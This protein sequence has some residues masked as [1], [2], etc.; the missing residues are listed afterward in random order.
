[1][2]EVELNSDRRRDPS[3]QHYLQTIGKTRLLTRQQEFE[4]AR[5]IRHGDREALDHLVNANLRFVVSVAKRY[6]NKGLSFMDLIAE[7]NIGLITAAKRFDERRDFRFISYA[8]WWIR[9]SIQKAI[10]EQ[11]NTVRLPV[12]R[13]QQAQRMRRL[14]VDLEQKNKREVHDEEIAEAMDLSLDKMRQINAA[15]RAMISIDES[16]YGDEMPLTETLSDPDEIGPEQVYVQHE[17][18][19]ELGLALDVLDSRERLIV[20]RY[21]GLGNEEAWSLEA[22]GQEMGLSRERVRQIRNQAL[23]R[24]RQASQG[25][26]LSDFLH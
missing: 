8:V 22:I 5:R 21:Y 15:T 18:A 16:A 11:T 26:V 2:F 17:L 10:A 23:E 20:T 6:L 7:G 14:A 13:T 3:L 1:M 12:N 24:M 4:L 25:T 19:R 9:Q